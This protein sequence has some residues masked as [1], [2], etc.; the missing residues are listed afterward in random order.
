MASFRLSA[1]KGKAKRLNNLLRFLFSSD[2]AFL[3]QVYGEI[4][5]RPVD[6]EGLSHFLPLLASGQSRLEVL[7]SL[8]RSQEF[9][10]KSLWELTTDEQNLAFLKESYQRL[11]GRPIDEEGLKRYGRFLQ[12]GQ[13]REEIIF[14]LISSDEWVS[15]ILQENIRLKNISSLKPSQ[16]RSDFNL[17]TSESLPTFK[18]LDPQ[19]FDWLETMIR[20][21]AYYERPGIWSYGLDSDKQRAAEIAFEFSP[22]KVLEIGCSSGAILKALLDRGVEGEGVEISAMAIQRAF[23]EIKD[24]I[25]EGDLLEIQLSSG[26][27]LVLGLDI[28]EHLNPNKM[29]H[30]IQTLSELL[31]E[32]GYCFCNIPAFGQ[33]SVFGTVFPL[34]LKDWKE[35]G[36]PGRL[37]QTLHVDAYGYPLHGHLIWADSRWWVT[38][39]EKVG[40]VREEEIERALHQKYDPYFDRKAP[41]RKSFYVFSKIGDPLR[42]Q[43]IIENI[44]KRPSPVLGRS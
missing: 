6:E 36:P 15:K 42:N 19:D 2:R 41:A 3:T 26:Y 34:Y 39:F 18:I 17:L 10:Q 27:D 13:R 29:T 1:F 4:F 11:F 35:P 24:K 40:L 14:E 23:P 8:L 28:F 38:Q 5:N 7:L 32:G 33:D 12:R 37:F 30:Y 22:Q 43:G 25:H 21:N 9:Y 16:Y 31:K 20:Q 44:Q